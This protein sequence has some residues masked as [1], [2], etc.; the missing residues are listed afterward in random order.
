MAFSM[1]APAV[2]G[3]AASTL[4]GE[5]GWVGA[6]DA[7]CG[8]SSASMTGTSAPEAKVAIWGDAVAAVAARTVTTA[9]QPPA[10]WTWL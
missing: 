10:A 8:L 5:E 6:A 4:A 1:R 9:F 3:G 2:G 7:G